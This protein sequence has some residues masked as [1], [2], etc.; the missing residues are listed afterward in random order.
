MIIY[1]DT[2]Q[3]LE[4]SEVASDIRPLVLAIKEYI[5]ACHS[6]VGHLPRFATVYGCDLCS[7]MFVI[8]G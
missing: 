1:M 7:R 5:A 4:N 3:S 2:N 6:W 8:S